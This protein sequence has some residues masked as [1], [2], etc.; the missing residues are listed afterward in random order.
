MLCDSKIAPF[1][2]SDLIL[3]SYSLPYTHRKTPLSGWELGPLRALPLLDHSAAELLFGVSQGPW[4]HRPHAQEEWAGET[5]PFVPGPLPAPQMRGRARRST[6][7]LWVLASSP[8]LRP[9]L[10][11]AGSTLLTFSCGKFLLWSLHPSCCNHHLSLDGLLCWLRIFQGQE[12]RAGLPWWSSG[13]ES[14][15]QCRGHRFTS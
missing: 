5:T 9:E 6:D 2:L 1:Y 11:C 12:I 14:V 3:Q 10:T 4:R 8:C 7:V 15:Y 13:R